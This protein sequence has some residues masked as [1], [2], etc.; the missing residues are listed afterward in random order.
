MIAKLVDENQRNWSDLVA[1]VTFCYNATTHSSTGFPPFF[2][3]TGHIPLWNVDL[4]LP[5]IEESEGRTVPEYTAKV[6]ERLRTASALVREHLRSA[7]ESAS[8]WYDKRSHPKHFEVGDRVRIFY[9]R[10]YPRRTS[11]WQSYYST[12]GVVV[13]RYNDVTYLIKSAKWPQPKVIHV[14]K[15]R[16]IHTFGN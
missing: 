5:Q 16:P 7:A 13:A 1:Y 9:P 8:R 10:R 11:K 4:L 6:I 3:Y 15:L 12:E 14:D 2:I